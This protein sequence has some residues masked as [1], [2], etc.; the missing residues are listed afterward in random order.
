MTFREKST[1]AQFAAIV[2]VYGFVA[3]RYWGAPLTGV[4]AIEILISITVLMILIM[5]PAHIAF[6]IQQR[7]ENADERD[8]A[9]NVR[10]TRNAYAALGFGFWCLLMMIV[11]KTP[12][13]LLFGAALAVGALAELV[14]LGSQLYYY[15]FG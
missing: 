13:G 7:P 12:Y 14:R 3:I 9:V 6:A 4:R 15:R 8:A 2:L 11:F 10:G 5:V 1:V